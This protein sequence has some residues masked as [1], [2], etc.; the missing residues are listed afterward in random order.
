VWYRED[1]RN[2]VLLKSLHTFGFLQ[3]RA[4][5]CGVLWRLSLRDAS[6]VEDIIKE[7][8]VNPHSQDYRVV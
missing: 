7:L 8:L 3:V 5:L 6:A 2:R 4:V 1:V